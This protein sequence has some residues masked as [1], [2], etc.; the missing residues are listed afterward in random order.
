MA[1]TS[2]KPYVRWTFPSKS[3]QLIKACFGL[4]PHHRDPAFRAINDDSTLMDMDAPISMPAG[5]TLRNE[6][7]GTHAIYVEAVERL[8][9]REG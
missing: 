5:S 1:Q 7:V 3:R 6:F 9:H 4:G 2:Q 8:F